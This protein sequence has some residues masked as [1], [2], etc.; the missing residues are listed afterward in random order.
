M[1]GCWLTG[2]FTLGGE[3]RKEHDAMPELGHAEVAGAQEILR[4]DVALA[5][6]LLNNCRR[7]PNP[8]HTAH[9][10]HILNRHEAR[11]QF[12]CQP[13][14]FEKQRVLLIARFSL[15]GGAVTLARRS[16]DYR[17]RSARRRNKRAHS[18][19]ADRPGVSLQNHRPWMVQAVRLGCSHAELDR[20]RDPKTLCCKASTKAAGA[21][22]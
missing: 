10:W 14:N 8:A 9:A 12:A 1:C 16:S 6:K 7:E 4:G 21:S 19:T 15:A 17:R 22:E 11:L 13:R 3:L 5:A 18:T 2:R 20:E